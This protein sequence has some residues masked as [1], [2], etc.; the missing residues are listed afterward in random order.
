M[1]VL[2]SNASQNYTL[3]SITFVTKLSRLNYK[4]ILTNL[5][6]HIWFALQQV[7]TWQAK[8]SL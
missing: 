5:L 7:S 4:N 8:W 6:A 3:L 1:W 2:T